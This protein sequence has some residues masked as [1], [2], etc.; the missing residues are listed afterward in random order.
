MHHFALATNETSRE[1]NE[2][3]GL[4]FQVDNTCYIMALPLELIDMKD[5]LKSLI[6][7]ILGRGRQ[8]SHED[9]NKQKKKK[10]RKVKFE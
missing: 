3:R 2:S 4:Y 10:K 9:E 7:G 1:N 6:F 8:G 5:Y